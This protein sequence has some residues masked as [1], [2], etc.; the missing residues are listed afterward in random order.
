M[1]SRSRLSGRSE[2]NTW[3]SFVDVLSN[4]LLVMIFLLSVFMLAQFFLGQALSGRDAALTKLRKQV[5]QLTDLLDLERQASADLRANIAQIS[6]SLQ[7]SNATR[8]E[9]QAKVED[10]QSKLD[11]AHRTAEAARQ[12]QKS[13]L[14][15]EHK[16]RTQAEDQVALLNEQIN[17][18]RKQLAAL[19][20]ALDASEAKDKE[21]QAT[22]A[23]LGKRLNTALA[24]KVAELARY[25]S[26]FFGRLREVIGKRSDI[27]VVGDRFVFSSEVLFPSGSA[28]ITDTGKDALRNVATVILKLMPKIP[29]DI[30]WVLRVDGHTD[31]VPIHTAQFASNW[32]LSS[33]RAI[34]VV[35]FLIAQGVPPDRL[36]AAGFGQY[37]PIEKGDTPEAR[38]ANRRIELKLTE[39]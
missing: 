19:Q 22:I 33:A 32:E 18:V 3:P 12:T 28:T 26:E 10:L 39:G 25:R 31:D 14:E 23:E 16:A 6:A 9:L 38:A 7:S 21:S 29:E 37:Q 5:A 35:R 1:L 30:N 17:A 2:P 13:A 20:E 4:L 8:D 36:A 15:A 34:S 27:K 24:S 11:S